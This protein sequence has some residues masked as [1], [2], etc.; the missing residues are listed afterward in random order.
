MLCIERGPDYFVRS[1]AYHESK[2]NKN[3]FNELLPELLTALVWLQLVNYLLAS[4]IR[5]PAYSV[6]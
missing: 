4:L 1:I 6:S 3:L 5:G 2:K